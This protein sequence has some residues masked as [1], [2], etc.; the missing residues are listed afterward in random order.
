MKSQPIFYDQCPLAWYPILHTH[1]SK[2]N[3]IKPNITKIGIIRPFFS[4]DFQILYGGISKK[5]M[6]F[7]AFSLKND[8][9]LAITP[10]W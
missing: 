6:P 3:P 5:I 10:K 7:L 2:Q 1:H 8:G 4:N 9:F